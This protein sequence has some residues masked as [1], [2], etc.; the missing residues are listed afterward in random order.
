MCN[1]IRDLPLGIFSK[2]PAL[3]LLYVCCTLVSL[4]PFNLEF[5]AWDSMFLIGDILLKNVY[6]IYGI[7]WDILK[8]FRRLSIVRSSLIPRI[9]IHSI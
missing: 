5:S 2:M 6:L 8:R 1:K 4:L 3:E 9:R 7:K